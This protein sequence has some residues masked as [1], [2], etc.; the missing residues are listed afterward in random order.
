MT[1]RLIAAILIAFS[2]LVMLDGVASADPRGGWDRGG[3]HHQPRGWG[4]G[5]YYRPRGWGHGHYHPRPDYNP[6]P[7]II[8]G[9]FGGWLANQ[10]DDDRG[11][12][13]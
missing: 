12:R 7:G 8:G 1:K 11:R 9:I 10:F 5:G 2:A 13:R 3:Y 6:I 4:W